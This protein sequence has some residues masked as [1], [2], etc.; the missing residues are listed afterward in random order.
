[1]PTKLNSSPRLRWKRRGGVRQA[2]LREPAEL[3]ALASL[4][5]RDW[6]ALSCP[7]RGHEM[8]DRTLAAIDTDNDG[9]V[10]VREVR[11]VIQWLQSVLRDLN[12]LAGGTDVIQLAQ[13]RDDTGE[14]MAITASIRHLHRLTQSG[15]S[16]LDLKGLAAGRTVMEKAP[17]DGDGILDLRA[18]EDPRLR[19]LMKDII[20]TIGP[21]PT[22]Q[23][24]DGVTREAVDAFYT[25]CSAFSQWHASGHNDAGRAEL[26]TLG[27]ATEAA[28][29]AL[30]AVEEKVGEWFTL[31][32]TF[33]YAPDLVKS[34][35]EADSLANRP[36]AP[37]DKSARL[38]LDG[39]F[40]PAW[41]QRVRKWLQNTVIPAFGEPPETLDRTAWQALLKR[42]QP[43]RA[44]RT[45]QPGGAV[46]GLGIEAVNS[47]LA[48]SGARE[49]LLGLL[50]ADLALKGEIEGVREVERLLLLKRDFWEF[51]HNFLNFNRFYDLVDQAI[52]QV[53]ILYLD[54]R[55]FHLCVPVKDLKSHA[56]MAVNS[57]LY[58]VYCQL[59]RTDRETGPVIVAAVT[60]GGSDRMI[61]GKHGVF[62]DRDDMEWDARIIQ[63]VEHPINLRQA[64]YEPFRRLGNL[65]V[66]H[67]EKLSS[68]REKSM[69]AAVISGVSNA[70]G[71]V[72]ATTA[73]EPQAAANPERQGAGVG[74]FMAGGGLAIAAVTS[75]L[76]FVSSTMARINPLYFLWAFLSLLAL[77][78]LPTA[79]IAAIRLRRRDIG[80]LLEAGGWAVNA[81]MRLSRA[82]GARLTLVARRR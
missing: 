24:T 47:W 17:M 51:I 40:N 38:P 4:N 25:A 30:G 76:A 52:F 73:A 13:I 61:M 21:V 71:S 32:E 9:R 59:S 68:T 63:I 16:S 26:F 75:S 2:Q 28:S 72:A 44:W 67:V 33:A 20:A 78:L 14:G 77:I 56:A 5:P 43:Y 82:L 10:R 8:D 74:S 65:L 7:A 22:R 62:Y 64:V 19:A 11:A 37:I 48:D 36:L 23:G 50:R 35:L 27:E 3:P 60:N 1:M 31:C 79:I 57:G 49:R 58:L 15:D 55:S 6:M 45:S 80:L 70:E 54:G 39:P 29:E 66:S 81:P 34:H 18:T 41:L 12:V 69:Q 46:S 53:G 42:L